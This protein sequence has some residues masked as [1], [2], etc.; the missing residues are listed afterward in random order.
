MKKSILFTFVF[1][2]LLFGTCMAQ[3]QP[4][5]RLTNN[6]APSGTSFNN[7]WCVAAGGNNVHAV[8]YDER[9]GN[10][11]IYYKRSTDGGVSWFSD[12]R[13]TNNSALSAYPSVAVSGT[14]VHIAWLDERD[15]NQEIYFKRSTNGG[16]SWGTD[17]RL[18]N[19]TSSSGYPSVAVSGSVVHVVWYDNRD[20]N[21]EIYYKRSIDGGSSW[22]AADTRL[23]N[24]SSSSTS[25][26][27]SVSGSIVHVVWNDYRDG[28]QEVYYK[29]ST[30]GGISWGADTR[31]TNNSGTSNS[32][33]VSVSGSVVHAV[34]DDNRDGNAE[35]YYK[36][37]TNGGVSWGADTRLTNGSN[38]SWY[39]SVTV[40]GQYVHVVWN[41]FLN[42]TNPEIYYT[43]SSNGGTSWGTDIRLTINTASSFRASVAVSGSAAHVVWQEERDGNFEI[44]Y[45]RNPTGNPVGII[46]TNS[47]IPQ[48]F[49]LSQNYPNPFNPATKIRFAL[50][51]RSFV[52]LVVYD[53]LGRVVTTLANETM[54]AGYY[55]A[56]FDGTNLAGG[57]YF[58]RINAGDFEMVKKLVLVK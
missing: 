4:D 23:T 21:Q 47:E 55:L 25:P 18:T 15:G 7:A 6:S 8:W 2:N 56:E 35:I 52:T 5:H 20:G 9:D 13:L 45:K 12:V 30:D 1:G 31:L 3:W 51:N 50:P 16:I 38:T 43:Q 40:S 33:S 53:M 28:N 42:V 48:E 34:W 26:S 19:A 41:E 10:F 46:N 14:I 32:P 57:V 17:V 49:F 36:R 11:E 27:A 39:P 58:Y 44:Y 37:S 29:R 54:E 22:G 24:N